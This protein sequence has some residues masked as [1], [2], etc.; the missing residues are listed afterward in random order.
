LNRARICLLA[1]LTALLGVNDAASAETARVGDI[2]VERPWARASISASRPAAAYFEV[3]NEGEADRL[4]AIASPAAERA[5]IHAMTE[6][7]GV[8]RMTPA[9]ALEIPRKTRVRLEPGG[10]HVMLIGLGEP[11]VE[12]STLTL[13]L[14]FERSG[15]VAVEAPV[16]GPGSMGPDHH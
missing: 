12:S 8:M 2:A 4:V 13:E 3:V 6:V 9:G 16:L 5:E 11:L 1:I 14:R 10:L 7:D 15:T